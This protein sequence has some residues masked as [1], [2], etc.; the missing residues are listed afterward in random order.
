MR[1]PARKVVAVDLPSAM[2]VRADFTV[3]F[4]APKAE[5]L[6]SE[7]AGNAGKLIVADIGIPADLTGPIWRSPKPATSSPCS[8]PQTRFEQGRL[9]SR[10]G[11]GRSPGKNR[12][13][14]DERAGGPSDGRGLGHRGLLRSIPAGSGIDDPAARRISLEKM[15]VLAIG[16]GLGMNRGWSRGSCRRRPSRRDRCGRAELNRQVPI[17]EGAASRRC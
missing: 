16:P 15:T 2:L 1:F 3:T 10:P 9:R 5:M 13:G 8:A 14:R 12:R 4:A 7:R 6:L 17:F 11:R